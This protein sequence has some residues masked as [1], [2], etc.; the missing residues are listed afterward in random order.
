MGLL[1]IFVSKIEEFYVFLL[2]VTLKHY[3]V[4]FILTDAEGE[5]SHT[6]LNYETQAKNMRSLKHC[7]VKVTMVANPTKVNEVTIDTAVTKS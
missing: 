3:F 7:N 1:C 5:V 2:P 6:L 4:V